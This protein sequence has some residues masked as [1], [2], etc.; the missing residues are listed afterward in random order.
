MFA[1]ID[2]TSPL[3]QKPSRVPVF[4]CRRYMLQNALRINLHK[5]LDSMYLLEIILL[6][7]NINFYI[8]F[9]T[10]MSIL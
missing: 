1:E 7:P 3:H 10:S 4:E 8:M 9:A 5:C 2:S 6:L